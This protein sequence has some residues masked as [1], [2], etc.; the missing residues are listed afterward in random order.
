MSTLR[1][2]TYVSP[3]EYLTLER[4]AEFRSEYLDG[5]VYAMTGASIWHI[6]IVS[7]ITR[8]LSSQLRPRPCRVLSNEMKVRMPDSRKFFYPDLTVVC[9]EPQ[10]HDER[11]DAILNPQLVVEVLSK[12][13]EAFDRG[14]KFF[15]Y[16]QL[17]S[18]AEY[19]LVSQ[20]RPAV[21][22]FVRQPDGTWNY[23]AAVGLESSLTLPSVECT[24]ELSAVYDKV[25]WD[26]TL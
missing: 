10:F 9:G 25:S 2:Q 22:Q 8:E 11:T 15:A 17:E 7:N 21:E 6:Q 16:Q 20:D 12:G 13:T 1:Q 18:L 3:E 4:E 23:R 26:Q 24:I 14:G 5:E 19:V